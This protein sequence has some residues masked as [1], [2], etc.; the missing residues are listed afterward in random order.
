MGREEGRM[1]RMEGGLSMVIVI[2]TSRYKKK[3]T[4]R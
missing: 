1:D 3:K 2:D 4:Q